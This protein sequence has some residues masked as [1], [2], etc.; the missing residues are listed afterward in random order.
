V[1]LRPPGQK[2]DDAVLEEHAQRIRDALAQG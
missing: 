2:A 1:D